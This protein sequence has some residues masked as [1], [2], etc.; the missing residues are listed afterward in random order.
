MLTGLFRM[1]LFVSAGGA[2]SLAWALMPTAADGVGGAG[3]QACTTPEGV[4]VEFPENEEAVKFRCGTD[5]TFID[6]ENPL[7]V[8]EVIE[9]TELITQH[10]VTG[11]SALNEEREEGPAPLE[12]AQRLLTHL[13]E[14][15]ELTGPEDESNGKLYTLRI[16]IASRNVPRKLKY[17]CTQRRPKHSE[18]LVMAC[19]V[20]IT[21]PAKKPDEPDPLP[22]HEDGG[23]QG[24][25]VVKCKQGEKH[26]ALVSREEQV[27][28]F[29]CGAEV[30]SL[31]P[32]EKLSV[33]DNENG[34]CKKPADLSGLVPKATRSEAENGIYTVT[35]PQLPTTKQALCYK[36]TAASSLSFRA[37]DCEIKI[38][39]SPRASTSTPEPT[40]SSTVSKLRPTDSKTITGT[41]V[42]SVLGVALV[43]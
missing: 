8:Y 23:D 18:D 6:P 29:Q 4:T 22:D 21:V 41:F 34:E 27:V 9:D 28:R 1:L 11:A 26:E 35:F 20:T 36:C 10:L 39:V 25:D 12:P 19:P 37:S 31:L 33:F 14:N 24:G 38:T 30:N 7:Y 15:A 3:P 40:T 17:I 43:A 16:P 13:Y 42:A 32:P 5:H 2:L